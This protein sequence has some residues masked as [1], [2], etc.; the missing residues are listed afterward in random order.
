MP[1]PTLKELLQKTQDQ[2]VEQ[3]AANVSSVGPN[4]PPTPIPPRGFASPQDAYETDIGYDSPFMN[5]APGA[6]RPMWQLPPVAITHDP[7]NTLLSS[8]TPATTQTAQ[9]TGGGSSAPVKATVSWGTVPNL[10]LS[11]KINGPVHITATLP[12]QSTTASDPVQLAFYRNG[13][14]LSQIFQNTTH[15]NINTPTI[16]SLSF[17]DPSPLQHSPLNI[18]TYSLFWKG[19][20]GN[21]SSPGVARSMFLTSLIPH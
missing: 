21:I 9:I 15:V 10:E 6:R 11:L 17:V 13:A 18:E 14:L 2:A 8:V 16:V 20:S 4:R 1:A 5:F 12:I 19:P 3:S 7:V